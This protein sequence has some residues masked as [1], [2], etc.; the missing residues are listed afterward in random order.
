MLITM[1]GI[2]IINFL[3]AATSFLGRVDTLPWGLDAIL[4]NAI[5]MFRAFLALFPPL[6]TIFIAFIIYLGFRL[7]MRFIR[8]IP[9]VGRLVD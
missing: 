8:M 5:G 7:S 3:N 2:I 9:I 4:T 1:F 6:Q